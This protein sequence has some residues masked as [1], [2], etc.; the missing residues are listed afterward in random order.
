[1]MDHGRNHGVGVR[2]T[3]DMEYKLWLQPSIS[4]LGLRFIVPLHKATVKAIEMIWPMAVSIQFSPNLQSF[5]WNVSEYLENINISGENR[6]QCYCVAKHEA[7]HAWKHGP[8]VFIPSGSPFPGLWAP[9]SFSLSLVIPP[10]AKA[11]EAAWPS[12][13][14]R[15]TA[16][17]VSRSDDQKQHIIIQCLLE[18][19]DCMQH[20]EM[21]SVRLSKG[22]SK[23]QANTTSSHGL[24]STEQCWTCS[25]LLNN[26]YSWIRQGAHETTV[27]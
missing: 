25:Y 17:S 15:G 20:K 8:V 10:Y 3:G 21:N 5:L 12:A 19:L 23:C 14:W 4:S 13:G 7:T 6:I 9:W 22:F 16:F 11:L 27:L 1:M 18:C 2:Q 24:A 26:R